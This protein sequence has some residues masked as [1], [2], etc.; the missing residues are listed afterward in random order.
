MYPGRVPIVRI[1]SSLPLAASA[2]PAALTILAASVERGLNV[3][4]PSE[5]RL[6]LIDVDPSTEII[7]NGSTVTNKPWVVANAQILPGRTPEVIEAFIR[8]FSDD[9]ALT[10]GVDRTHVRVLVDVVAKEHWG[11]G[12]RSAAASA[13]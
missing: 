9:I 4:P 8:T 10:F 1:E 6:R 11:I 7:Y 13:R 2:R 12:G 5:V 3:K